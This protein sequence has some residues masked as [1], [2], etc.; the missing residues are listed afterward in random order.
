VTSLSAAIL[1]PSLCQERVTMDG[2]CALI[3][4]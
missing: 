1:G 3:E 2:W 4:V